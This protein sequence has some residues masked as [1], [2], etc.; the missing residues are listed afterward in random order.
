MTELKRFFKKNK[1]TILIVVIFI[2]LVIIGAS[3]FQLLV[4]NTGKAIYGNRLDGKVE[5][6]QTTYDE[7]VN[8][9]KQ[10]TFVVEA[11][12]DERGKLINILVTVSDDTSLESA[13]TLG[14]IAYNVFTEEQKQYYDFQM[15]ITKN[16]KEQKS[17]PIMGYKH[18][19]SADF[20]WTKDRSNESI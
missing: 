6:T 20:V 1:F 4:P 17:F 15:I 18:P 7:V 2:V 12:T 14:Q 16:D 13:K 11:S 3:L 5:V 9:L 8:A 10:Q 19:Q